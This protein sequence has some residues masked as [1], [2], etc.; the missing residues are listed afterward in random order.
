MET[1]LKMVTHNWT[2]PCTPTTSTALEINFTPIKIK[3][4]NFPGQGTGSHMLHLR[5]PM[6]QQGSKTLGIASENQGNATKQMNT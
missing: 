4:R 3:L 2:R 1:G 5:Y 6:V